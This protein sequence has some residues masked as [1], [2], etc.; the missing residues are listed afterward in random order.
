MACHHGGEWTLG[1]EVGRFCFAEFRT[2]ATQAKAEQIFPN[3]LL[4][5][6]PEMTAESIE[7]GPFDQADAQVGQEGRMS[8]PRGPSHLFGIEVLS[9]LEKRS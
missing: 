4:G 8:R 6:P 9:K 2:N 5:G 3:D 1:Q 7:Q